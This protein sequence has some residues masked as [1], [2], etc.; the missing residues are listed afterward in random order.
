MKTI[1][2]WIALLAAT[3]F[4][5]PQSRPSQPGPLPDGR[6]LLPNG[7]IISPA[8]KEEPLGGMPLRI[9][10]VPHSPYLVVTSNGFGDQF[11]AVL[12]AGNEQV[13]ERIPIKQ[14]WAGLAVSP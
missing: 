4:A 9:V 11:L 14:G 13:V 10:A 3:P 6:M 12:N 5:L 2:C 7:W 8:G 1:V